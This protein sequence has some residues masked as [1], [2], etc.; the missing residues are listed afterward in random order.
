MHTAHSAYSV[1]REVVA[2]LMSGNEQ[3]PSLP[4]ITL[5]IR[6][7]LEQPDISFLSLSKIIAK[8]PSLSALLLKYAS[9]AELHPHAV[10][11]N[12]LEVVRLLGMTQ[13][14]RITMIHSVQS[15]FTMHSVQHKRL[16][17]Q[18]WNRVVLKASV[19]VFIARALGYPPMDH[20][21]LGSLLS[22]IG[23]LAV[24]S[25]F[26]LHDQ[27]PD[28]DMYVALCREYSKS[29]GVI[30]LK[31]WQVDD[32]YIGVIRNTGVWNVDADEPFVL[33][34]AINLGLYHSLKLRQV[35]R[36][37]PPLQELSAYK[38]LVP[39]HNYLSKSGNLELVS[40]HVAEIRELA[41]KLFKVNP[42]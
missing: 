12:L 14:E 7:A 24:L 5:E 42:H 25:A 3:L 11:Q 8:D 4:S 27:S 36:N 33:S 20:V 18:A 1:Y 16:F 34:D 28:V 35:G 31:K 23:T 21:L 29:L 30:M 10:P 17:V 38:K 9:S 40:N 15:L 32:E 39:P 41:M 6:R 22:E 13:V 37:L 2:Q 26:K 19:S